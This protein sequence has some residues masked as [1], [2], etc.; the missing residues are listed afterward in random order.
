MTRLDQVLDEHAGDVLK[1]WSEEV[2]GLP[3]G[4]VVSGIE[5]VDHVP[6]FLNELALALRLAE[7]P[8]AGSDRTSTAA[9]HG[10]QRYRLGFDLDAVVREYGKLHQCILEIAHRH[11]VKATLGEQRVLAE[12]INEGIVDAITQYTRQRDAELLRQANE[13]FAFVAHELR[14]PLGAAELAMSSLARKGLL[15]QSSMSDVLGRALR[16][17]KDLIENTLSLMLTSQTIELRLGRMKISEAVREAVHDSEPAALDKDVAIVVESDSGATE[18]EI[19]ADQRLLHSAL[20][21]LVSNAVKF[22]RRGEPV[23]IR[24]HEHRG[25]LSLEIADHC[26]GLPPDGEQDLCPFRA[27]GGKP[28]RV[29]LG[30]GHR[31][32]GGAGARGHHPGP[33][34]SRPRLHLRGRASRYPGSRGDRRFRQV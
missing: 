33:Q 20:T 1:R 27:D 22:T 26:G 14:N 2:E 5:L 16:R 9:K 30:A 10:D 15:P 31:A 18:V 17:M 19:E 4:R 24:W 23:R 3:A 11:G 25:M 7:T 8:A 21:N 12:A 34:S 32:A 28:Q 13:H 6:T 29:R